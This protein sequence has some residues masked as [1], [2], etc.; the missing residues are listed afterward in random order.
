MVLFQQLISLSR[1]GADKDVSSTKVDP[2][3]SEVK[4]NKQTEA[5]HDRGVVGTDEAIDQARVDP[6]G[7]RGKHYSFTNCPGRSDGV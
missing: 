6:V 1:I 5:P 2:L 4:Y 7:G 3:S